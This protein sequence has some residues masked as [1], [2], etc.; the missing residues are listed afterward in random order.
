M[1]VMHT[2][3][4]QDMLEVEVLKKFEAAFWS[5]VRLLRDN[6]VYRM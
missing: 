4:L 6:D 1:C 2:R 3:F 5:P